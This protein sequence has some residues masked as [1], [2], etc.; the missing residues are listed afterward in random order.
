MTKLSMSRVNSQSLA[1]VAISNVAGG[2]DVCAVYF[3][4]KVKAQLR[5]TKK[6]EQVREK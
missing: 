4:V 2:M 3:T 5:K 6:K 1:G